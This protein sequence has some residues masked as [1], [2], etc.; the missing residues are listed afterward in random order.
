[1]EQPLKAIRI[2]DLNPAHCQPG[3]QLLF[4]LSYASGVSSPTKSPGGRSQGL[5]EVCSLMRLRCA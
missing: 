4:M 2:A 3:L 1:M 5:L